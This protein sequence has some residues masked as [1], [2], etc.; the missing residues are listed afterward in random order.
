MKSAGVDG[1]RSESCT[2]RVTVRRHSDYIALPQRG[3]PKVMTSTAHLILCDDV[4]L[5]TVA[6]APPKLCPQTRI[7]SGSACLAPQTRARTDSHCNEN[8]Q[9]ACTWLDCWV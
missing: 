7:A 8:P 4:E 2:T 6:T 3:A 5:A 1:P 9:D